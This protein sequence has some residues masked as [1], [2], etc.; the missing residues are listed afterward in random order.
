[1]EKKIKKIMSNKVKCKFCG[2]VIESKHIH[3]FVKCSCGKIA[4]DGGLSYLRRIGDLNGFEELSFVRVSVRIY[5]YENYERVKNVYSFYD[6]Y[7]DGTFRCPKCNT[8][9]ISMIKGDGEKIIGCDIIALICDNCEK[10]YEFKDVKYKKE[11]HN[12]Q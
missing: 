9:K 2:D 6:T 1:M 12:E 8:T 4:I 11:Y 3:D 10:V 5:G 7:K